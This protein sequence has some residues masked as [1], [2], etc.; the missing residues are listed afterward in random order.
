MAGV[1]VAKNLV[2]NPDA[3]DLIGLAYNNPMY[4]TAVYA[5]DGTTSD[6]YLIEAMYTMAGYPVPLAGGGFYTNPYPVRAAAI[7]ASALGE[8]SPAMQDAFTRLSPKVNYVVSAGDFQK[9]YKLYTP[10]N[11]IGAIPSG[12]SDSNGHLANYSDYGDGLYFYPAG[13][14]K[15]S[16]GGTLTTERDNTYSFYQGTRFGAAGIAAMLTGAY[17]W[18]FQQGFNLDPSIMRDK[19]LPQATTGEVSSDPA[20]LPRNINYLKLYQSIIAYQTTLNNK[21]PH[22]SFLA[23]DTTMLRLS[24][25]AG[26]TV[27]EDGY[28]IPNLFKGEQLRVDDARTALRAYWKV[29]KP[30][31]CMLDEYAGKIYITKD[32][33]G[34]WA[35]YGN[36]NKLKFVPPP[37]ASGSDVYGGVMVQSVQ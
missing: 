22:S 6:A 37:S 20:F 1:A 14:T 36:V 33:V 19:I 35:T 27:C 8:C 23:A 17:Q 4:M 24:R 26:T 25:S 34:V 32:S 5:V 21:V 15:R 13:E 31:K 28:S 2:D 7:D 30:L 9:D 11:C 10:G 3:S 18:A 12:A 16:S 29:T